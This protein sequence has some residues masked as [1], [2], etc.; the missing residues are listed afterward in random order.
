MLTIITFFFLVGLM[1]SPAHSTN[2]N[3]SGLP[4]D[5]GEVIFQYKEKN[6]N[7]LYIIGMGHRDTLTRSNGE[8]THVSRLKS[9]KSESG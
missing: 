7:Q 6:P 8:R 2:A 9:I 5:Y 1:K 3:L 4:G